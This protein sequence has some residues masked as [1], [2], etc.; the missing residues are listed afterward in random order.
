MCI[1]FVYFVPSWKMLPTSMPR[2][3]RIAR[4]PQR[5]QTPPSG[6]LAKSRYAAP[7]TSRAISSP[8][9]W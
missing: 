5:G 4:F 9:K 6:I 2:A 7:G 8:E 1:A 3:M